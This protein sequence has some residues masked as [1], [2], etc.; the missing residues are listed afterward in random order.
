MFSRLEKSSSYFVIVP[1]DAVILK[2]LSDIKKVTEIHDK[3]INAAALLY[4]SV[5]IT[6]DPEIIESR[7]VE[8]L[9]D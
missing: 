4:K 9:W 3:I 6:K 8:T 7:Y 1:L 2:M 5:L